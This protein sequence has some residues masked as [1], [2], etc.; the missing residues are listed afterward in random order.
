MDKPLILTYKERDD[1]TRT[2][3][4]FFNGEKVGT[5]RYEMAR[6]KGKDT[7]IWK[8]K[9]DIGKWHYR[10]D[11]MIERTLD[12]VL[13]DISIHLRYAEKKYGLSNA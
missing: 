3:D 9:I 13:D 12:G 1:T 4:F 6:Y 11:A 2:V 7:P 5:A 8:V 10:C